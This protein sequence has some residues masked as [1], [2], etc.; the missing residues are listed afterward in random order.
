MSLAE[1]KAWRALAAIPGLGS[2]ALW[3]IA[4]LLLSR[5]RTASWLLENPQPAREIL[6]GLKAGT[7]PADLSLA[8]SAGQV[9]ALPEGVTLL[10]P[11]HP[12]FP[13]R[14]LE[15]RTRL[16]LPALL[17][18]S[19]DPALLGLP[20]VAVVGRRDADEEARAIAAALAARLAE[21]G[22]A[23]VSGHAA[24]IDAAAHVGALRAGGATLA[25]LPEGLGGFRARP[26][27]RSLLGAG[28]ALFLS[29]FHPTAGWAPFQAMA[30]NKLVAALA[31]AMVVVRCGPERDGRGRRSGTFDAARA[32]LELGISLFV[33][34]PSAPAAAP[35]GNQALIRLGGVPWDP[36]Q[37][38]DPIIE[39]IRNP[40]ADPQP[41]QKKLF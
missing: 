27:L 17:Y 20:A 8:E 28:Q 1:E 15:R 36:Q 29:Q 39:A 38:A 24:G 31:D 22:A 13:R 10:H 18:A 11:L 21:G 26:E 9:P 12:A 7:V 35:E 3:R 41:A 19:G 14:L 32:A 40:K 37:G 4:D 23:V 5:G 16:P 34:A 33:A 2:K 25:V 6:A 30:R